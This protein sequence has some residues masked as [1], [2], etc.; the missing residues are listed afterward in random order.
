M[1]YV[2]NNRMLSLLGQ[3]GAFGTILY[4]YA[5]DNEKIIA[6]SADLTR[7]SGLERFYENCPERCLNVGIAEQNA[8]GTAAGLADNGFIPFVTTF[9]NFATMR[10]NEFVRHFMGYM[11]CSVKLVGLAGGF[12]MELFGNTHYGL[13]DIAALKAIPNI[14]IL[15]PS[16]CLEVAKCVEFCINHNGPVYL[17]LSGRLNNPI[18]NKK[19]YE[20]KAGKGLVLNDGNDAV[21]YATGSMV[22]LA[23]KA[24]AELKK[25]HDIAVK[26]VNMH[27]I[28]PF[29]NDL[30]LANKDYKL[31]L[32]VE[33]H[34]TIGGL[35]S[36]VAE[37]LASQSQHGK[38]IMMG[39][40]DYYAKAGGY[41]YMLAQHN[42]N[43]SSIVE[44]VLNNI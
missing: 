36:A 42:L 40:G 41:E 19:D 18:V 43:V 44:N 2:K 15:S 11:N 9:A 32:S 7:A 38:L 17:R 34:S 3:R 27:T 21:M 12:A 26:V 31:I 25:T 29:D 4:N 6:L 14:T 1:D 30:V 10:A 13:E 5:Q 22:S 33:E 37:V 20:F 39:T 35:G 8:V 23:L 16:D 28:K 24:A